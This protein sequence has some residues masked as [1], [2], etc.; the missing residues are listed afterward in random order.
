MAVGHNKEIMSVSGGFPGTINDKTM[1]KHD[2]F[3]GDIH[4]RG[5]YSDVQ[6]SVFD[7]HG[8]IKTVK[9]AW[10]V[11]DN[12]YNKY[13][14]LQHPEKYPET[15]ELV[16]FSKMLESMRKDV[17]C[18]FGILKGRWRCLKYGFRF[19]SS[20]YVDNTIKA[21][22]ILH[23]MLLRWDGLDIWE[24]NVVYGGVDGAHDSDILQMILSR[25]VY[26]D[27]GHRLGDFSMTSAQA[28]VRGF[29]EQVPGELDEVTESHTQLRNVLVQNFVYK[30][31]QKLL[32]WPTRN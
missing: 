17:E 12:G 7:A 25:Q 9:G 6:Y 30:H 32:V 31:K 22:C 28:R 13:K 1:F 5:K 8:N 23:N 4:L 27:A 10:V 29:T 21:C 2:L 15:E 18:T 11:C 16:K 3:L 19:Q 20:Q 26:D 24:A 14:C